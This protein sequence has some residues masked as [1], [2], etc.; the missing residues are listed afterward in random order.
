MRVRERGRVALL[1]LSKNKTTP[2]VSDPC[3]QPIIYPKY[4]ILACGYAAC[5]EPILTLERH[6]FLIPRY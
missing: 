6:G 5:A 4:K 3:S 2:A 1:S